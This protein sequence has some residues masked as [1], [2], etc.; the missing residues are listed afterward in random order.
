MWS[1]FS[2]NIRKGN[3]PNTILYAENLYNRIFAGNAFENFFLDEYFNEQY[4]ADE[5]FGNVF[6]LFTSL[7]IIVAC[8]GLIGLS[9]FSIKLRTKEIGIRKVLGASAIG[10]VYLFY[11]DFVRLVLIAAVIA[12]PVT[13]IAA[14]KWLEN[15]A[16]RIELNWLMF[17]VSVLLL[18]IISLLTIAF[19]SLK[20]ALA[21]PI[22]SLRTD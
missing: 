4:L 20:A 12:I 22:K 13:Y 3:I 10:I 16:F 9:T 8:I 6:A 5:R 15:F 19:Q 17:G 11:K 7:A 14:D 2:I 18:M 21:N 1:C